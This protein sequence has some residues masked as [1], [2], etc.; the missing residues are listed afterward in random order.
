M[1]ASPKSFSDGRIHLDEFG[2]DHLLIPCLDLLRDQINSTKSFIKGDDV[3]HLT[4][5]HYEELS[6][7]FMLAWTT[8][9]HPQVVNR[10]F[11]QTKKLEKFPRQ[12]RIQL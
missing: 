12:V 8:A 6:L 3:K 9:H 4:V 1:G 2:L 7:K 10:Y 11:S 5:P